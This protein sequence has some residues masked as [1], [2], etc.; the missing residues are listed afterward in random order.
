MAKS[1]EVL[2]LSRQWA[3]GV[4]RHIL[5]ISNLVLRGFRPQLKGVQA[6]VF[7][8]S[9]YTMEMPVQIVEIESNSSSLNIIAKIWKGLGHSLKIEGMCSLAGNDT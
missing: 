3:V 9:Q 8:F 1:L 2:R 6:N 5:V 7:N 4:E